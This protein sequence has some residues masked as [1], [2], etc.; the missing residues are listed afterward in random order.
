[1]ESSKLM[2]D[3]IKYMDDKINKDKKEKYYVRYYVDDDLRLNIAYEEF[4]KS[5]LK[6]IWSKK[7]KDEFCRGNILKVLHPQLFLFIYIFMFIA[8]IIIIILVIRK[9]YGIYYRKRKSSISN[10]ED[11]I[12]DEKLINKNNSSNKKGKFREENDDDGKEMDI[13]K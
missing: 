1:M 6:N 5:V 11:D 2:E 3:L 4:K 8:F 7:D 10:N 13:I 12:K 9:Y